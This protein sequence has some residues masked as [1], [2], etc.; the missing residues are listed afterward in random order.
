M[1]LFSWG[2]CDLLGSDAW[3]LDSFAAAD[4][5]EPLNGGSWN[6]QASSELHDR[7]AF[8]PSGDAVL[9]GECIC[10]IS[11]NT[12]NRRRLLDGQ[13]HGEGIKVAT[14]ELGS[15]GS[16][17]GTRCIFHA[18]SLTTNKQGFDPSR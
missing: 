14:H 5:Q 10:G 16:G 7:K 13:H 8:C 6:T 18:A 15:R 11:T 1:V 3:L 4:L 9:A 2:A 12:Q 17:R